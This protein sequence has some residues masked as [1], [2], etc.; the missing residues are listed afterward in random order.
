MQANS[1]L[2]LHH[3]F[4]CFSLLFGAY[5]QA[6]FFNFD[7]FF[8]ACFWQNLSDLLICFKFGACFG[9]GFHLLK[10]CFWQDFSIHLV[11]DLVYPY[12][13]SKFGWFYYSERNLL[14]TK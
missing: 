12:Q 3:C 11:L 1:N 4:H 9:Q 6:G 8:K 13:D 10:A 2:S 7:D 5:V 14:L